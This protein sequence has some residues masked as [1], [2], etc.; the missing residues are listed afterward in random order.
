MELVVADK[1][2]TNNFAKFTIRKGLNTTVIKNRLLFVHNASQTISVT[3]F[4]LNI[5]T[6]K[7]WKMES[8]I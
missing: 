8:I 4:K 1:I 5:S 6:Q 3:Y 2:N 7:R